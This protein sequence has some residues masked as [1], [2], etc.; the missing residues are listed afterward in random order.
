MKNN[1]K[2]LSAL[3][4]IALIL[5]ACLSCAVQSGADIKKEGAALG[6]PIPKEEIEDAKISS[7]FWE[8]FFGEEAEEVSAVESRQMLIPGG[9]VFGARIKQERLT[10]TEADEI[11]NLC[12]GD[13]LISIGGKDVYSTEDVKRALKSCNGEP[14]QLVCQRKGVS[15]ERTVT[16]KRVGG[17]WRLGLLLRDGAAGIGTLTFIN[18][19]SLE[20]GG[21]GHGI[22]D[23]ESKLPIK[24]RTGVVTG[25]ILGGVQ[26]G[27]AGNPGELCGILKD[28][29]QGTLT[30]NTACGVFGRLDSL[31]EECSA[32]IPIGYKDEVKAG[33]A[34]I[35][36]TIKN[37]VRAEYQI[38]ITEIN[39]T[40]DNTKSFKIKVTDPT[41]IALTGG[42]VR[43][44]SGSP[45]I[46]DGKLVGAVTHVMVANPTEGYGIFIENMLTATQQGVQPKAA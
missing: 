28:K 33:K 12:E 39:H 38:E 20:F 7:R 45:I 16:P 1:I 14:I 42:I 3:C 36:S 9:T 19:E 13:V 21:L 17:E 25:V 22:C 26:K 37:G 44:M 41:L 43:G 27:E 6:L 8:L 31:P 15:I 34:T 11:L 40:S 29:K 23:T 32:A 30:A 35:I 46:Q 2:A 5:C 10:V 18:P 24:M 4:A